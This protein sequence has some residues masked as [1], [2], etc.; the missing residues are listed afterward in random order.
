MKKSKEKTFQN[1]E[2]Q[3]LS[4]LLKKN[5]I[6]NMYLCKLLVKESSGVW[7]SQVAYLLRE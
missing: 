2:K 6:K 7:R 5:L 4:Y 3:N 1:K